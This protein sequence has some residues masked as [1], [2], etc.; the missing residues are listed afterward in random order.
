ML[1]CTGWL[2]SM[3]TLRYLDID[4]FWEKCIIMH[5]ICVSFGHGLFLSARQQPKHNVLRQVDKPI[6]PFLNK[7]TH[8]KL[9]RLGSWFYLKYILPQGI[10]DGIQHNRKIRMAFW[11]KICRKCDGLMVHLGTY[12]LLIIK[13]LFYIL[14]E[15]KN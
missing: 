13:S 10:R 3:N 2:K 1:C 9:S 5:K 4:P 14:N 12:L 8:L 11:I 7:F 6:E 15:N